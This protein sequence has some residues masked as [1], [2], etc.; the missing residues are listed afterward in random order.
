MNTYQTLQQKG[1]GL[2][3]ILWLTIDGLIVLAIVGAAM[4][5]LP[6]FSRDN[7]YE[8]FYPVANPFGLARLPVW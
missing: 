1:L 4:G 6:D 3:F 7:S 8:V 2:A 5:L